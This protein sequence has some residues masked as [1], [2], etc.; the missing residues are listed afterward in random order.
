V[1]RNLQKY[2]ILKLRFNVCSPVKTIFLKQLNKS[3]ESPAILDIAIV[4]GLI[5][6]HAKPQIEIVS[7]LID[8]SLCSICFSIFFQFLVFLLFGVIIFHCG[9]GH[10]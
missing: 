5:G 7:D 10:S 3:G 1:E 2:N 8:G 9:W 4:F 6:F